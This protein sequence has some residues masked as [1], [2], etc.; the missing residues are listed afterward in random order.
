MQA[1]VIELTISPGS[2]ASTTYVTVRAGSS[3]IGIF[4]QYNDSVGKTMVLSSGSAAFDS[5]RFANAGD[6]L[7]Y[8]TL[9]GG[10]GYETV[11][12]SDDA[13]RYIAFRSGSGVGWFS[14]D[15]G[16]PGAAIVYLTDGGQ[17]GSAGESLTVGASTS[18]PAV[19]GLGGLAALAIG[20]GGLRGR[21]Q[22]ADRTRLDTESTPTLR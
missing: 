7:N 5:W 4:E 14:V 9:V 3:T 6:V 12:P 20:A 2:V 19:P 17:W 15:F 21:R 11:L 18:G 16:G 8:S 22:R 1:D 13:L 10:T